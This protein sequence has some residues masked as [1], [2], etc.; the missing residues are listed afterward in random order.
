MRAAVWFVATDWSKITASWYA[1]LVGIITDLCSTSALCW[2]DCNLC[3]LAASEFGMKKTHVRLT[4]RALYVK[5]IRH[6][7]NQKQSSPTPMLA[8]WPTP[9][10]QNAKPF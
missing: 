7:F 10:L 4:Q 1:E 8:L 9:G 2:I 6:L 3:V 5:K